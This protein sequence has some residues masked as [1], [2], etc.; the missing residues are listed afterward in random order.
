MGIRSVFVEGGE[1]FLWRCG[2]RGLEDVVL[3]AR[4]IGLRLVTLYTN[5]TLPIETSADTVFVSLDGL[6]ETNDSLRG[7]VYDR[8]M[9]N[10][11]SSSHPNILINYTINTRNRCDIEP[12]CQAIG[13]HPNIK[14]VFFHF[15]TPYYGVDDLFLDLEQ[16]RVT[17]ERISRLKR[18]GRPILNSAAC[19]R[20]V[21]RDRWKRPSRLCYVYAH[22]RLYQCCRAIGRQDACRN[23]G[24][25]GYPEIIQILKLRP[26]AVLAAMRYLPEGR[27]RQG[28]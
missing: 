1:P 9:G 16:R 18:K 25:L 20:A 23:C 10:I 11:D 2:K 21:A 12:F 7:P 17:I 13:A 24:Y 8:V 26:S 6:K 19:L 28:A 14:G 4:A 27:R 15:H 22:S 3:A 5:G